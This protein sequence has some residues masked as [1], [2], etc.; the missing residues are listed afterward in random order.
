MW[1]KS[2]QFVVASIAKNI[3]RRLFD[4]WQKKIGEILKQMYFRRK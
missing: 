2:M 1:P 3:G 4:N